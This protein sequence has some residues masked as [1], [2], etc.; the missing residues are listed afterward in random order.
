MNNKLKAM[1]MTLVIFVLYCGFICL[2]T[3]GF[4]VAPVFTMWTAGLGLIISFLWIVYKKML[5]YFES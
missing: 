4:K 5:D 3:W 1:G 2:L